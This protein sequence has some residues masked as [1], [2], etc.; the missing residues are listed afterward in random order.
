MNDY[1]KEIKDIKDI[2]KELKIMD[3]RQNKKNRK[4]KQNDKK[5]YDR[6]ILRKMIKHTL[7][8]NK[9]KDAF[10]DKKWLK[11]YFS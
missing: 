9:I 7:K 4:L 1:S 8:S 11:A 3:K 10:H 2:E 5:V 6:K